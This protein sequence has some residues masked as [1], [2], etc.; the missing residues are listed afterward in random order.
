MSGDAVRNYVQLDLN[1]KVTNRTYY[2]L[3]ISYC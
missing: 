2:R 1:H 3:Y